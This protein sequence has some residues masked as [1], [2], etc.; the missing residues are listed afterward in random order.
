[1][2]NVL[3]TIGTLFVVALTVIVIG[4]LAF[5]DDDAISQLVA[6]RRAD[7]AAAAFASGVGPDS[8]LHFRQESFDSKN[9]GIPAGSF[10]LPVRYVSETWI[11]FGAGGELTSF[12]STVRDAGDGALL[13][14]TDLVEGDLVITDISTGERRV[15]ADYGLTASE[16]QTRIMEASSQGVEAARLAL[17]DAP[18]PRSAAAGRDAYRVEFARSDGAVKRTYVDSETYRTLRWEIVSVDSSGEQVLESRDT[19][20]FEVLQGNQLPSE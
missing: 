7:A 2:K 3:V 19:P 17:P 1:M 18:A 4:K 5:V 16:L 6:S 10:A 8:T 11:Y 20:V 12:V 13:Q 9:S 14:R 15:I